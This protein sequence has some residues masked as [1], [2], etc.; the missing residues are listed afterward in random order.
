MATNPGDAVHLDARHERGLRELY[1]AH[2]DAIYRL[3]V[4]LGCPASEVEDM[5]QRV[6]VV[7]CRHLDQGIEVA[8]PRAWLRGIAVR[9]HSEHRRFYRVRAAKHWLLKGQAAERIETAIDP[10]SALRAQ[11]A[12]ELVNEV[13][14]KMSDKL[15]QV[16]VLRD[17]EGSSL[18]E[19]ADFLGISANTVRSRTRL[20]REQFQKIWTKKHGEQMP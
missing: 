11:Q 19:T 6:F 20:A 12:R 1:E 14:S 4:Y 13:L 8:H 3:V 16:L 15:R 2:V 10:E 9:L 5:T 17:I 7:A 18:Q